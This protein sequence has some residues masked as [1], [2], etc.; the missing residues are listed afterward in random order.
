MGQPFV[1]G[2]REEEDYA[3]SVAGRVYKLVSCSEQDR[4]RVLVS[5]VADS[6]SRSVFC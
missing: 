3:E 4:E 1:M 2:V 5:G 6:S